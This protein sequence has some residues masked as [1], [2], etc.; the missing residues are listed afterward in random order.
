MSKSV[1][2]YMQRVCG[3]LR[4]NY[5]RI[6]KADDQAEFVLQEIASDP[7][8]KLACLAAIAV[9]CDGDARRMFAG[10]GLYRPSITAL[11]GE[12]ASAVLGETRHAGPLPYELTEQRQS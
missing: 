4:E 9:V 5:P 8:G 10:L 6:M 11:F 1:H 12:I 3:W 2:D 7:S